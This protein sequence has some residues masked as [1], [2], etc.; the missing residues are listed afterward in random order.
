M[1]D[2]TTLGTV[3][4]LFVGRPLL[5]D[6][7]DQHRQKKERSFPFQTFGSLPLN[8]YLHWLRGRPAISPLARFRGRGSADPGERILFLSGNRVCTEDSSLPAGFDRGGAPRDDGSTRCL[9]LLENRGKPGRP[10]TRGT[11]GTRGEKSRA[12]RAD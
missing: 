12:G 8:M 11:R 4:G 7:N 10:G 6:S 5:M 2:Y 1:I 9:L 3:G